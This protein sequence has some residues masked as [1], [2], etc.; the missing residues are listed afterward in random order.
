MTLRNSPISLRLP[1]PEGAV[2]LA[3]TGISDQ[4][5]LMAAL[6]TVTYLG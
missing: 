5:F 4:C 1:Q 6:W 2:V 3:G